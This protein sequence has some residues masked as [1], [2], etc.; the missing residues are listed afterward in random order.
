MFVSSILPCTW[1]RSSG[2][3]MESNWSEFG[4]PQRIVGKRHPSQR[5][6]RQRLTLPWST[7]RYSL[8]ARSRVFYQTLETRRNE[9]ECRKR[10]WTAAKVKLDQKTSQRQCEVKTQLKCARIGLKSS[11]RSVN[12]QVRKY[13]RDFRAT[14]S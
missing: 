6:L 10:T 2:F 9:G 3:E 11:C 14:K 7:A 1:S 13:V 8:I 5:P 4:S 12:S